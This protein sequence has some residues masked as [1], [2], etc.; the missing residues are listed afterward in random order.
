[1]IRPV[2]LLLVLFFSF[3]GLADP[4]KGCEP[5]LIGSFEALAEYG[6]E[7][8]LISAPQLTEV[9]EAEQP[10]NP[11]P[12]IGLNAEAAQ[13]RAA[14]EK[15]V[16][17]I[18]RK[19]WSTIK[20][21]LSVIVGKTQQD[22]EAKDDAKEKTR[23][24]LLP[25]IMTE[26][27]VPDDVVLSGVEWAGLKPLT[28]TLKLTERSK[29]P[30]FSQDGIRFEPD[31]TQQN[32][33]MEATQK[34]RQNF[35]DL[36]S[37]QLDQVYPVNA[38]VSV[39]LAKEMLEYS[40]SASVFLMRENSISLI[41]KFNKLK[42]IKQCAVLESGLIDCLLVSDT[43]TTYVRINSQ[44][45]I[46]NQVELRS[47]YAWGTGQFLM[48]HL[49]DGTPLIA[50]NN[51]FEETEIFKPLESAMP[52]AVLP[53]KAFEINWIPVSME[54]VYLAVIAH[55]GN[56]IVDPF[57]G[58]YIKTKLPTSFS[59]VDLFSIKDEDGQVYV[60]SYTP[61]SV[62]ILKLYSESPK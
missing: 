58:H 12:K 61:Q 55:D 51:G 57:A 34:L 42:Q 9:I 29:L 30:A 31:R 44:N 45:K 4:R 3:G 22:N 28:M 54:E 32:L 19:D 35:S 38:G 40:T 7:R 8:K 14:F 11:M 59:V 60:A 23:I 26:F 15:L 2:A 21:R 16:P 48:T 56:Y 36:K 25:E 41:G 49:P 6:L 5:L 62:K 37:I 27:K 20:A 24:I 10:K 53:I 1:M 46:Q 47:Q 43:L 50:S 13:L 33:W 52:F 39:V 18:E 17:R